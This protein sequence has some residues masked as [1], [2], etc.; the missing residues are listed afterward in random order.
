MSFS[1]KKSKSQK[2]SKE[3]SLS[4]ERNEI[5]IDGRFIV[6]SKLS[7]GSFGQVYEG[8][9]THNGNKSIICKINEDK[10]MNEL[11]SDVLNALND[12]KFKNFPILYSYGLHKN[13]PYQIQER[14]GHTLEYYQR[15]RNKN[16]FTFKTVHQIGIQVIKL[17]EQI[18]STGYVYNDL[19]PDNILLDNLCNVRISDFG[20]M[21][22]EQANK[23][24]S[25]CGTPI[26]MAPEF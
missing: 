1:N 5:W 7:K 4:S 18:H 6:T 9:D 10:K 19:K 20:L 24:K 14:F 25:W 11:E 22:L 13:K 8:V 16:K 12:G 21:T 23:L 15:L 2:K 26:F 3:K 17:L